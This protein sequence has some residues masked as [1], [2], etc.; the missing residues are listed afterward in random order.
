MSAQRLQHLSKTLAAAGFDAV[1]LNPGSTLT[2]LTGL[3]FH[4]MERPV[5]LVFAPGKE[6]V[7]ILPALERLKLRELPYPAQ[8]FPY[9]ENPAEW[10][11]VFGSA[12]S[13]LGLENA[14]IGVEPRALRL[15][16]YGYL[17]TAA[18]S[19]T[20]ADASPALSALRICKDAEEISAMRRA[21]QIAQNALLATLPLVKIGMTE[22]ELASELV[23][24]LLR[25][26]SAPELPFA[27]IVS[28]GENSAN[29]HASPSERK[30]RPGDLL[31]IDWG[32]AFGGYISDLTRTFA[33]GEVQAE[34]AHIHQVVQEANAAGRAVGKPGIPCA[35]V[36]IAARQVIEQAGYGQYFTHRTGHG[37]GMEG[38]EDPYMRAD[39]QDLL[40]TGMAYTVEPGIYLPGR[41][42]VR[43]EDDMVVTEN[44]TESL[45]NLPREIQ[46]LG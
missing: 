39:N 18:P 24:Q 45:S 30:L 3:Q 17:Q 13:A 25:H 35:E 6:P 15:L 40:Q 21:V 37:I 12:L 20:F 22:R 10:G 43:I 26:G 16:E 7:I 19:A 42:G 4:L 11:A 8:A 31:V 44:G 23:L 32:A 5:V 28:G 33:I 29:P 1:A 46:V 14:K 36:D 9:G 2:Y 41:N 38:H 27:P 34:Y